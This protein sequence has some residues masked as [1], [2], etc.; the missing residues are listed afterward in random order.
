VE[1]DDDLPSHGKHYCVTCARYFISNEALAG[2]EKTK[3]H[4][5]RIKELA[6]PP[7]HNQVDAE[8]AGGMGIPDNGHRTAQTFS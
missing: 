7:P 2:H 3:P 1:L 5:R 6:G 4:K 8:W